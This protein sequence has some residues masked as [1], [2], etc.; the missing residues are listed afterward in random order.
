MKVG[1]PFGEHHVHHHRVLMFVR[2]AEAASRIAWDRDNSAKS[3]IR[4]A[5]SRNQR[6]T[7]ITNDP[8][9]SRFRC[10]AG[11]PVSAARLLEETPPSVRSLP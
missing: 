10:K 9:R 2:R 5:A 4:T 6:T 7:G 3:A 1:G 11:E 8:R